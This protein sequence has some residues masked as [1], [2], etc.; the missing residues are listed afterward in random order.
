MNSVQT[1]IRIL[2][3]YQGK[4]LFAYLFGSQA[5]GEAT[6]ASDFD[7]AVY[8]AG[9]GPEEFFAVRLDLY[10]DLC[11]AL[12]RNDVDILILNSANTIL[13]DEVVRHGLLIYDRDSEARMDFE[14]KALHHAL[15]FKSQR[16]AIMEA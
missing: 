15:D 14:V 16:L 3:T 9:S 1:A 8:C 7:L 4:I 12:R 13:R 6:V 11:R 5:R 10:G 2:E